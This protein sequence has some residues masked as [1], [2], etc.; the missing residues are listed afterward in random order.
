MREKSPGHGNADLRR[1]LLL[2][3]VAS[4]QG[5]DDRQAR[6]WMF[7]Q[8]LDQR[9]PH[10]LRVAGERHGKLKFDGFVKRG[11]HRAFHRRRRVGVK[12][13][14]GVGEADAV[15]VL[16]TE[17]DGKRAPLSA[18]RLPVEGDGRRGVGDGGEGPVGERVFAHRHGDRSVGLQLEFGVIDARALVGEDRRAARRVFAADCLDQRRRG[19][20]IE[21]ADG[22]LGP[23]RKLNRPFAGLHPAEIDRASAGIERR[24]GPRLHR[25][26]R[27][28]RC[29]DFTG[30]QLI[31][32]PDPAGRRPC[33]PASGEDNKGG[34]AQGVMVMLRGAQ[35]RRLRLQLRGALRQ[36]ALVRGPQRLRPLVAGSGDQR[37][38]VGLGGAARLPGVEAGQRLPVGRA[39]QLRHAP[40]GQTNQRDGENPQQRIVANGTELRR[41]AEKH[42]TGKERQNG[43]RRPE[44]GDR[45]LNPQRPARPFRFPRNR[46]LGENLRRRRGIAPRFGHRASDP[47]GRRGL[48]GQASQSGIRSRDSISSYVGRE[49]TTSK[50]DPETSTSGISGRLLYSEDITAP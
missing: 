30:G 21:D 1:P 24:G 34:V 13:D 14:P 20:G 3:R 19:L 23:G 18:G 28:R 29:G 9:L 44:S 37:V 15:I 27:L 12:L 43:P 2:R 39:A 47:R 8:V 11:A 10:L 6:P 25:H 48:I 7:R 31:L 5:D 40:D 42:E 45:L 33:D 4:D 35:V 41:N 26:G 38:G 36:F 46:S 17:R 49:R 16:S 50:R 32:H 22:N